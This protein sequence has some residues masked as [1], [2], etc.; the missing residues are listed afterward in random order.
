MA[1][2]AR[3]A[4]RRDRPLR[5]VGAGPRVQARRGRQRVREDGAGPDRAGRPRAAVPVQ[6]GPVPGG[7]RRDRRRQRGTGRRART[8]RAAE[9]HR[10]VRERPAAGRG[11]SRGASCAAV[12]SLVRDLRAGD[13]SRRRAARTRHPHLHR[14]GLRRRPHHL[15]DDG[16]EPRDLDPDDRRTGARRRAEAGG[17][18]SASR[19]REPGDG[20]HPQRR[21]GRPQPRLG[22]R[23]GGLHA[24]RHRPHPHRL[25]PPAVPALPARSRCAA[26]GRSCRSSPSS[27]SPT[28]SPCSARPSTSRPRAP[29][30][31]RSSRPRSR[32]R[33]STWRSRT[34]SASTSNAGC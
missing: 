12:R 20:R 22:S 28:R 21:R 11:A 30:F 14:P 13:P 33:S 7:R 31:R 10:A 9:G 27:R 24:T 4:A 16:R 8:R 25:R 18:L 23:R 1:L 15:S 19:R 34:S 2:D 6:V 17:A 32:H 5:A 29:G 26:G 3:L